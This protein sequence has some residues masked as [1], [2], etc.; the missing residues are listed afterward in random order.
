MNGCIFCRATEELAKR[1]KDA[2]MQS[3]KETA[4]RNWQ[5]WIS[6]I[7]DKNM[8]TYEYS[9]YNK[10]DR[11]F[12]RFYLESTKGTVYFCPECGMTVNETLKNILN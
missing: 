10:D 9:Q 12:I 7:E 6:K 8:N 2:K 1:L 5:D 4:K 3:E 11:E